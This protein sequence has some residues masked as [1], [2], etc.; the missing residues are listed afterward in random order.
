MYCSDCGSKVRSEDKFCSSCGFELAKQNIDAPGV[1]G[2]SS[3]VVVT[4]QPERKAQT[5]DARWIACGYCYNLVPANDVKQCNRCGMPIDDTDQEKIV[6]QEIKVTIGDSSENCYQMKKFEYKV[7]G[8]GLTEEQ[9]Q[10][11][12]GELSKIELHLNSLGDDGWEVAGIVSMLGNYLTFFKR[13]KDY[14]P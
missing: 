7:D 9:Q 12:A 8:H 10:K 13:E 14:G 4:S 3:E 1:E 2:S 11:Y 6:D 5:K